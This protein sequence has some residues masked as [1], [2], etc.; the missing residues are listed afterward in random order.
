MNR[1]LHPLILSLILSLS[2]QAS[3]ENDSTTVLKIK[4]EIFLSILDSVINFEQK[5]DYYT[6]DLN[7][8]ISICYDSIISIGSETHITKD[9]DF[10]GC[11][12]IKDHTFFV[13]G[14]SLPPSLFSLTDEKIV[15]EYY[16]SKE[17]YDPNTGEVTFDIIEDDRFTF[18]WYKYID[19]EFIFQGRHSYCK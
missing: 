14:I 19:G 1:I 15:V 6:S 13:R 9:Y 10:Y 16:D 5:C 18:W 2:C 11:F 3:A 12:M 7:F 17:T 8:V 4:N